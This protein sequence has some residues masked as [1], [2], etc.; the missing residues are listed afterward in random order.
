LCKGKYGLYVKCG[1]KN[2]SVD[3]KL[4]EDEIDIEY[5][6]KLLNK[7]D[8]DPYALKSFKYADKTINIKKGPYGLYAQMI[9]K[10]KKNI[11]LPN[12]LDIEKLTIEELICYIAK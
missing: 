4:K 12:N 3:K 11:S 1:G 5:V 2:Y 6:N 7:S 8:G 10:K 9:G